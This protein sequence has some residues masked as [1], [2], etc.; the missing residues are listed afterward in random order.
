MP[1]K[2]ASVPKFIDFLG[3]KTL[4]ITDLDAV[5][6]AGEK[7]KVSCGVN[8][9]NSAISH[10]FRTPTLAALKQYTLIDK[11]FNKNGG[12][13]NV[14]IDG[15]LCVVYQISENGY[16]ARSFEDAFIH[17][18]KDFIIANRDKFKGL[19]HK[20]YFDDVHKDAYDLASD[21]IYKKTYFAMDIIFHTDKNFSNWQIPAYIK[22]GLLWLKKD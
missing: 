14:N 10:Y 18:N 3:I 8:Y 19:K 5:N 21:C 2:F 6:A 13:W 4:I 12:V 9:S 17:L 1:R 20:N 16:H 15:R 22:E 11:I 7:C